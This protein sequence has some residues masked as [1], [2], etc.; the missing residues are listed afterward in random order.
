[1][2]LEKEIPESARDAYRR[3]VWA[4]LLGGAYAGM[5]VPFLG[6]I[7]RSRLHADPILIG[8]ITAAPFMGGLLTI[9]YSN[10]A[11]GRRKMPFVVCP[12]ALG[13]AFFILILFVKTPMMF[14]LVAT[15]AQML[16][17]MIGPPY[18]AVMR[19]VYPAKQRGTIMAYVRIGMAFVT[20]IFTLIA[21]RLMSTGVLSYHYVMPLGALAGVAGALVFGTI[22]TG[23]APAA[24]NSN[25]WKYIR[26]TFSI[27]RD[28]D[29]KWFAVCVS[30]A[31]LSSL[32]L[33]PMYPIFQV[34]KLG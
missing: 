13:R 10:V 17:S 26:E 29:N 14:A 16:V 20:F 21:G 23:P 30:A 15:V 7:A 8:L 24:H 1:M 2:F 33:A 28:G 9:L 31:G 6:F 19:E 32:I 34:D 5:I 4:G 3:D 22:C 12:L 18:V 11:E 27:L 25:R